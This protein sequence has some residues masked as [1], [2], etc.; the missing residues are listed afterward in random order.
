MSMTVG[1]ISAN[2]R[3]TR[4]DVA[5]RSWLASSKR[6][7]SCSVRTKARMTRTPL[8]LSRTTWLIRSTLTCIARNSGRARR[9]ITAMKVAM[10][11]TMTSRM[12]DSWASSR[13]A[14]ITPPMAMIG[15]RIMMLR[16]ITRT[17]WTCWTSLVLRVMSDGVPNRL[18]SVWEKLTTLWKIAPRTSRPKAMA[19][20]EPQ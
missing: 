14:M 9:I 2:S 11:G 18:V 12:S 19:V 1:S 15:A 16:P 5:V 7:S 13:T 6:R 17:I 4:R 3:L 20:F 10:I 8:R